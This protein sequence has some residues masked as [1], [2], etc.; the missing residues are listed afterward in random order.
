MTGLIRRLASY[1]KMIASNLRVAPETRKRLLAELVKI[2][3]K[4]Y[5]KS[6]KM[7]ALIVKLEIEFKEEENG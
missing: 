5:G 2:N 1:K 3:K 6:V 4:T 7:D